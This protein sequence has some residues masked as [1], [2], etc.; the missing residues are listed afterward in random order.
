MLIAACY[1][2]YPDS[3]FWFDMNRVKE[4]LPKF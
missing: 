1:G 2:Q 3:L 4:P